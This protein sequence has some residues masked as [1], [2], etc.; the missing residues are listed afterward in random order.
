VLALQGTANANGPYV[1]GPMVDGTIIPITPQTAWSTGQYNHMPMLGGNVRDEGNFGIGITEYFTGPP[2][3][4]LT[5]DQYTANITRI[6]SGN[7]GPG[8][9]PPA[10]PAGTVDA[11]LA[12]YP[13]SNYSSPQTAY[14]YVS[15]DPGACRAL[16]VEKLWADRVPTYAYEFD[17]RQAPYYFPPMPE[18]TPLAAH[19]IDI[20]FYFPLWHGGI[21]GVAH[22]L[23]TKETALSD[24][25]VAAW[26]LFA[27]DGNPNGGNA[28]SPWPRFVKPSPMMYSQNLNSAPMQ[29]G[30]FADRHKCDF[31][32]TI[33]IY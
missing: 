17:Y 26:T 4:P 6:Y 1:T 20:Q 14:D 32:N 11:V 5:A 31:W 9:T 2:Q 21:L 22:P 10:Y 25:L 19:T 33:L 16:H 8:G 12:Q 13:L 23:N 24:Q 30:K 15:T 18:F 7:A 28:D 3:V 29:A 27:R